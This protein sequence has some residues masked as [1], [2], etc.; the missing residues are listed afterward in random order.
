MLDGYIPS[1]AISTSEA[2]PAYKKREWSLC[3]A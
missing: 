2:F 1:V 3:A